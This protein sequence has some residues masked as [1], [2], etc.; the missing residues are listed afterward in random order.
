MPRADVTA[1]E[2][3]EQTDRSVSFKCWLDRTTAATLEGQKGTFRLETARA[4]P[5]DLRFYNPAT[6]RFEL[7][8]NPETGPY[9]SPV[10][11][12]EA[13]VTEEIDL[14]VTGADGELT[15]KSGAIRIRIGIDSLGLPSR[16]PRR[17]PAVSGTARRPRRE[18]PAPGRPAGVH[19][20][21]VNNWP[22]QVSETGT[23][24]R[25]AP[26]GSARGEV[27]RLRQARPDG[28]RVDDPAQRLRD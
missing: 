12:D 20:A 4:V 5:V 10:E 23:S 15:L 8:T 17:R 26:D 7:R 6:F 16:D 24:F 3:Y 13:A 14:N 28:Q 2:S 18:G 19:R 9:E 11:Y 25:L 27:Y 21:G 22:L 1:V